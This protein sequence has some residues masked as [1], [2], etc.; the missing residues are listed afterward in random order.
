MAN[1]HSVLFNRTKYQSFILIL[2]EGSDGVNE[3][4]A[5]CGLKIRC[6]ANE[7]SQVSFNFFVLSYTLGLPSYIIF[8]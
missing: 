4:R 8:W 5:D 6:W 1:G 7:W 2:S 3:T